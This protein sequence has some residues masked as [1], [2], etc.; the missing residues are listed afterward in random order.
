MIELDAVCL[1]ARLDGLPNYKSLSF[2]LRWVASIFATLLRAL[3]P[4][5]SAWSLTKPSKLR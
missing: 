4:L 2:F 3:I 1:F 5:T